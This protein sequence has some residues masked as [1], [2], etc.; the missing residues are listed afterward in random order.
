MQET[1]SFFTV[2]AFRNQ[3]HLNEPVTEA[4]IRPVLEIELDRAGTVFIAQF[5][6]GMEMIEAVR[7]PLDMGRCSLM[8]K[9]MRIIRPR[10]GEYEFS[11][12][13]SA[14]GFPSVSVSEHCKVVVSRDSAADFPGAGCAGVSGKKREK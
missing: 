1:D 4:L 5:I 8:L 2:I 14:S 13:L 11:L 9:P 6:D 7:Y 12:R 10:E 3:I